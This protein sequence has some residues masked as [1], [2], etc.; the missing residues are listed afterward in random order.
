MEASVTPSVG[1][2]FLPLEKEEKERESGVV[3]AFR[4]CSLFRLSARWW[5]EDTLSF[6]AEAGA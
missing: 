5:I 3:P 1:R 2:S 6:F 4:P